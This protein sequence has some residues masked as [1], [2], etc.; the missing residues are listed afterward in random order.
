M[1]KFLKVI[2]YLIVLGVIGV[3][4]GHFTF[5]ALS[6]SRSVE[7]PDLKG[8]GM[9]DANS[10]VKDKGLYLRLEGEDFDSTHPEGVVI[11][12]DVPAGNKVKEG[13]E[14]KV[15]LSKGPRVRYV[16]DVVGQTVEGAEQQ[17]REKGIKVK[18]ILYVHTQMAPKNTIVAQRPEVHEQGG[19]L[20][21]VVVSLGDFAEQGRG[22]D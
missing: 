19:D 13:R 11:R 15:I 1:W 10:I 21:S 16:P 4:A 6:Y 22:N 2:I 8:R 9:V 14:I 12:Q 3:V 18:R 20:F 17:L 7:V 5:K